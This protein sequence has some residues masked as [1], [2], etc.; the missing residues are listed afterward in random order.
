[1]THKLPEHPKTK[2]ERINEFAR[3][4]ES[5]NLMLHESVQRETV[6]AT[7]D[8]PSMNPLTLSQWELREVSPDLLVNRVRHN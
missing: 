1:M 4:L 3:L 6:H 8:S 2:S 5:K 7:E